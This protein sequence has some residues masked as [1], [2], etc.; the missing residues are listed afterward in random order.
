MMNLTKLRLDKSGV[1]PLYRQLSDA[2]SH[3]IAELPASSKLPTIRSLSHFLGINNNTVVSAYKYLESQGLVYSVVGSG[4]YSAQLVQDALDSVEVSILHGSVNFADASTG[5]EFFPI[6]AFR[7]SCDSVLLQDRGIAFNEVEPQGFL[8][9][10]EAMCLQSNSDNIYI[11]T[12]LSHVID[13]IAGKLITPGDVVL[14]ERPGLQGVGALFSAKRARIIEFDVG[15]LAKITALVKLHSPKFIFLMP[16]FQVPTGFCY[17]AESKQKLLDLANDAGVYIIEADMAG[18][19]YYVDKPPVT[20]KSLDSYNLVVYVKSFAGILA[21][22]QIAVVDCPITVEGFGAP[23]GFIQ[24]I[25]NFYLRSE[26]FKVQADFMRREY[27][28]RYH[29]MIQ[30]C[31][32][33]LTPYAKFSVPGG[34]LGIWV[35]PYGSC[36]DE[37]FDKFLSRQVVVSPG[38]MFSANAHGFRMNFAN[39]TEAKIAEGVGIIASVLAQM[40]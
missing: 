20:L 17:S 7:R 27:S 30:A 14:L 1:L 37:L 11:A 34:G 33:Y 35:S 28:K 13:E 32:T 38:R 40:K 6:D 12:G 5:V 23:A 4:F 18:D 31:E 21:G 26:D 10:R 36:N 15:D 8:P 24:R 9:L 19:F 3:E 29:K 25:V 16:N 22:L 2:M 39:V